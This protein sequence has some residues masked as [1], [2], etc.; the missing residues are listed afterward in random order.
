MTDNERLDQICRA[1]RDCEFSPTGPVSFLLR[2]LGEAQADAARYRHLKEHCSYQYSERYDPPTPREF[3]I[4]WEYQD[5]TPARPSM[6]QVIDDDIA[7]KWEEAFKE[8]S[9]NDAAEAANHRSEAP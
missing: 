9:A 2:L 6:D 8:E 4:Q 5:T 1:V 7:R 3:G